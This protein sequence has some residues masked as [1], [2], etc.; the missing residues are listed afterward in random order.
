[1]RIDYIVHEPMSRDIPNGGRVAPLTFPKI[2]DRTAEEM[3][4]FSLSLLKQL[5]NEK[6]DVMYGAL[7][8]RSLAIILFSGS[9]QYVLS[10]TFEWRPALAAAAALSSR[11]KKSLFFENRVF[12]DFFTTK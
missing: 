5:Q 12:F 3:T 1:M 4:L 7:F 11:T 2:S 6:H 9:K 8:W 10:D